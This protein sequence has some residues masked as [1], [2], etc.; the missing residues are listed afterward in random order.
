[1]LARWLLWSNVPARVPASTLALWYYWRWQVES[2]FKLLKSAGQQ[3][4]HWQQEDAAGAEFVIGLIED[5]HTEAL[6]RGSEK[7][8]DRRQ[9][10]RHLD[11]AFRQVFRRAV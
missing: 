1:M 4:E 5:F 2:Y 10:W 3:V 11:D 9:V 8:H 7:I 6:V